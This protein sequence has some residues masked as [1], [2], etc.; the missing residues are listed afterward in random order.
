MGHSREVTT[1]QETTWE[2]WKRAWEHSKQ[3]GNRTGRLPLLWFLTH[4]QSLGSTSAPLICR[5]MGSWT[6]GLLDVPWNREVPPGRTAGLATLG[7]GGWGGLSR[8]W[9]LQGDFLEE[10]A[11]KETV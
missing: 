2:A 6:L 10:V 8:D 5:V 3:G 1:A 9:I 11:P 7:S 4:I